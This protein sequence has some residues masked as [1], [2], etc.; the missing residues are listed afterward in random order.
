MKL[1]NIALLLSLSILSFTSMSMGLEAKI[2][3][4]DESIISLGVKLDS[5][6]GLIRRYEAFYDMTEEASSKVSQYED[7]LH[8]EA[9]IHDMVNIYYDAARHEL[10]ETIDRLLK[11]K[12]IKDLKM[13]P[14]EF[15]FTKQD[16]RSLLKEGKLE[17]LKKSPAM[18][19]G[20]TRPIILPTKKGKK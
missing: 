2:L 7:K 14:M 16:I 12:E 15:F 6:E 13:Q 19:E 8:K 18:D 11:I 3:N 17:V 10:S 9:D 4:I 1:R 20:G 5:K